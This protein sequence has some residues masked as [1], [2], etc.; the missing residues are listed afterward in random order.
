MLAP[1]F[2]N[3]LDF[4]RKSKCIHLPNELLT[5]NKEVDK[6]CPEERLPDTHNATPDPQT[7]NIENSPV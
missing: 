5:M 4:N 1:S 2:L 6:I 7:N 3:I